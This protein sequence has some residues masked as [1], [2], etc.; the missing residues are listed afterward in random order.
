MSK[1]E[2]PTITTGTSEEYQEKTAWI[3]SHAMVPNAM[4]ALFFK[5]GTNGIGLDAPEEQTLRVYYSIVKEHLAPG[6]VSGAFITEAG[7]FA[8]CAVWWPPGSHARPKELNNEVQ[9]QEEPSLLAAFEREGDQ[10]KRE[11]VWSK[12]GQDYWHLGLLARDPRKPVVAGAVRAVLQPV[13]DQAAAERKPIWLVTTS[14]H[15]RDIY[16]HYGW[17]VVRVVTIRGHLQWCMMLYPPAEVRD[18][19]GIHREKRKRVGWAAWA[20]RPSMHGTLKT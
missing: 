2:L 16:Q 15:A 9:G 6:I 14:E 20:G 5:D 19:E 17:Q 18:S 10:I 4:W 1:A 13:V 11:L 12:Y 3:V 8:A 7:D